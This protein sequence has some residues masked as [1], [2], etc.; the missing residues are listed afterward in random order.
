MNIREDRYE[1]LIR[2]AKKYNALQAKIRL[3]GALFC[4]IGAISL[5][6]YTY[7]SHAALA[8]FCALAFLG[9]GVVWQMVCLL[10]GVARERRMEDAPARTYVL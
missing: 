7:G 1:Q 4:A 6:V 10:D 5:I 9:L 2:Q 3:C 8:G